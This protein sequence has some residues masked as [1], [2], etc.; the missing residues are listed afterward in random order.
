MT[1]QLMV[2]TVLGPDKP[3]LVEVLSARAAARGANW[4]ASR[5]V[6][7]AGRFA[8]VLLVEVP[9]AAADD[10]V[11]D[12]RGLEA[13][14]LHVQIEPGVEEPDGPRRTH[15]LELVGHDRQGIVAEVA[16]L[17]TRRGVNVEEIET[18]CAQAPMAGGE[19]FKLRAL[20]RCPAGVAVDDLRAALEGLA[21][22]LMVDI[23]V[24]PAD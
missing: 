3:G 1:A 21:G 17:L 11:A 6:R 2:V 4:E 15:R 12:L 13:E 9:A 16:A 23:A 14:G 19:L 5:L 20:L 24:A 7:L 18:E 22:E 8:G 10:L